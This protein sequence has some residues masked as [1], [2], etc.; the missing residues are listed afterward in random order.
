MK[1]IKKK[2]KR[3]LSEKLYQKIKYLI[4]INKLKERDFLFFNN[5]KNKSDYQRAN[6]ISL[7]L[8]RIIKESSCFS[9]EEGEI[10]C[11]HMFRSTHAI[12]TFQKNGLIKA[13]EEL[14]HSRIGTTKNNYL[15]PEE[16]DLYLNEEKMRFNNSDYNNIFEY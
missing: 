8:N 3:K 12:E 7:K 13:G 14:G 16:N 2:P 9:K 6:Y 11:S 15:K 10:I 1:K 4:S 5:Y